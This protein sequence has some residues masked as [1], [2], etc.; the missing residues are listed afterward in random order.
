MAPKQPSLKEGKGRGGE[1][2]EGKEGEPGR[3]NLER[4]KIKCAIILKR[5]S[6]S[7]P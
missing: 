5:T 2:K 7:G 1:R 4:S 3:M 6:V